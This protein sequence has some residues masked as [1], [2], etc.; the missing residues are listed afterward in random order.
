M[1]VK[2]EDESCSPSLGDSKTLPEVEKGMSFTR[3]RDKNVKLN[4]SRN[5]KIFLSQQTVYTEGFYTSINQF[6][7]TPQLYCGHYYICFALL[8]D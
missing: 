4:I 7:L 1:K 5:S 2:A 3:T 8:L 6:L